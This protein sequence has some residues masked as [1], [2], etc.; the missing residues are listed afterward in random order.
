M[1]ILLTVL[2]VVVIHTTH[3]RVGVMHTYTVLCRTYVHR[4]V[5]LC[6]HTCCYVSLRITDGGDILDHE[7][8]MASA[9]LLI[10]PSIHPEV[11]VDIL[12]TSS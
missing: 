4:V 9:D 11:S 10:R 12:T 5:V 6:T 2:L 7:V 1:D 8:L 3:T